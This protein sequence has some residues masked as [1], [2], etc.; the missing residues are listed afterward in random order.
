MSLCILAQR[1][2][3]S[4]SGDN[5]ACDGACIP[6]MPAQRRPESSSGDNRR[7]WSGSPPRPCSLNEGRSLAPA[8]T[9][10]KASTTPA[11]RSAQRRPESS[12][13]DNSHAPLLTP[14][15][16]IAQRRPESSSGDNQCELHYRR[17]RCH[18]LNEGRSLAP[19]TTTTRSATMDAL[20][21]SAQRRPESS[22]GDN[23]FSPFA[24]R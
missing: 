4:S 19:A 20:I 10:W 14:S 2:P 5:M 7:K 22:S 18:P 15:N 1:R 24:T 11:L 3:E 6:R 16:V 23:E 17:E 21:V 9:R 8:T 12:S 13:G